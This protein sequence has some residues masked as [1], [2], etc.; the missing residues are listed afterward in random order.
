MT[1]PMPTTHQRDMTNTS[2][3]SRSQG[4]TTADVGV[5][6][7]SD[8]TQLRP[9]TVHVVYPGN[10][11][12]PSTQSDKSVSDRRRLSSKPLTKS[13]SGYSSHV[14]LRSLDKMERAEKAALVLTETVNEDARPPESSVAAPSRTPPPPPVPPKIE[15]EQPAWPVVLPSKSL[16]QSHRLSMPTMKYKDLSALQADTPLSSPQ[17]K[18]QKSRRKSQPFLTPPPSEITVQTYREI[19]QQ[20][21]PPVPEAV[22]ARLAER[23][24][25]FP[26][27]E[28]TY[29][30]LE[31]T[32]SRENLSVLEEDSVVGIEAARSSAG[33]APATNGRPPPPRLNNSVARLATERRKS[34]GCL[35]DDPTDPI[36][37]FGTVAESLGASPYD[38]AMHV[39]GV[40][41]PSR[42][43]SAQVM[44]G[45]GSY[46]QPHQIGNLSKRNSMVV[47]MDEE[48]AT[49]FARQRS[50]DCGKGRERGMPRPKSY[51]EFEEMDPPR[52]GTMTRPESMIMGGSMPPVPALPSQKQREKRLSAPV[53]ARHSRTPPSPTRQAPVAPPAR[54]E[55]SRNPASQADGGSWDSQAAMWSA[56]RQSANASSSHRPSPLAS[57]RV[58]V[59]NTSSPLARSSVDVESPPAVSPL[60]A[61]RYE[62][63]LSYSY[64]HGYGV[65]GSAGTRG[66]IGPRGGN[67][68]MASRKGVAISR[69]WGVDLSDVPVFV[70]RA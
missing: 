50:R 41:P 57:N 34:N 65:G 2:S 19:D 47:G 21:I 17:R 7:I 14:S 61:G 48:S 31:H 51:A 59:G 42:R 23:L 40:T 10:N 56:R 16:K 44:T 24:R 11:R 62:G 70:V 36:A 66:D 60:P 1:S 67:G 49:A 25:K 53:I 58:V 29:R 20:E 3:G 9:D 18:L 33:S 37:D 8:N 28:H 15:E 4:P 26:A 30:S 69:Q 55:A 38:I 39:S 46:P 64:E 54:E 27:L 43:Q 6:E 35:M 32:S 13:D 52:R 5:S 12:S 45:G 68:Q 22:A 63:G